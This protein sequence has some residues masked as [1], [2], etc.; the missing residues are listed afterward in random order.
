MFAAIV[1]ALLIRYMAEWNIEDLII[2]SFIFLYI[3]QWN[4]ESLIE[5]DSKS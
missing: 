2:Y 5:K 1:A 4:I 3:G